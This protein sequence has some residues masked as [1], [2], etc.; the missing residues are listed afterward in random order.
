MLSASEIP[1]RLA[2]ESDGGQPFSAWLL[3]RAGNEDAAGRIAAFIQQWDH[4]RDELLDREGREPTIADYA[5]F[6]RFSENTAEAEFAEFRSATGISDPKLLCEL[7]W[8]GMPRLNEAPGGL[9]ELLSV[10]VV[11]QDRTPADDGN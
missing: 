11:T 9:K 4:V 1:I 2:G 5:D 7:L 8:D 6:W 3:E 10:E